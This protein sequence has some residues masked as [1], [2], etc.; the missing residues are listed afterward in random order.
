MKELQVKRKVLAVASIG[1]HWIQLLRIAKPLQSN[2]EVVYVSTN[3]KCQS[4]VGTSKLYTVRD[5]CRWNFWKLLPVFLK[6][7]YII[8]RERPNT[9]LTTGAAPGLAILLVAK[10]LFRKTV[11]VDSVANVEVLSASGRMALKFAD[12]VF[13]QWPNLATGKVEYA[14]NIFGDKS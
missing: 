6:A 1:G 4:M 8:I 11:W 3:S 12:H 13:T 5:V 2:F 9:V 10:L 14:G 7:F